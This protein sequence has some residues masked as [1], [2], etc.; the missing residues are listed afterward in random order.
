MERTPSSPF[1]VLDD[2]Q[3]LSPS[4]RA[5]PGV[6]FSLLR[7]VHAIFCREG[8]NDDSHVFHGYAAYLKYLRPSAPAT[9]CLMRGT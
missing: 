8:F 6:P 5:E 2:R 3:S 1:G 9:G 4:K 7:R